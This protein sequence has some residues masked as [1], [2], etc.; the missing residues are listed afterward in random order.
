MLRNLWTVKCLTPCCLLKLIWYQS[1]Y[2]DA[3]FIRI[4]IQMICGNSMVLIIILQDISSIEEYVIPYMCSHIKFAMCFEN[5][6]KFKCLI[7]LQKI[8]YT[9]QP[10]YLYETINFGRS[11]RGLVLNQ[12]TKYKTAFSEHQFFIYCT[13]LWNQLSKRIRIIINTNTTQF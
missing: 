1:F 13:L 10:T 6:L 2:M 12:R 9:A 8:I 3:K 4:T 11:A 7:F 5:L